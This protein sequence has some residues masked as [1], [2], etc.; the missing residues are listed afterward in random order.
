LA[1][2]ALVLLEQLTLPVIDDAS[3]EDAPHLAAG[4]C[5]GTV[6]DELGWHSSF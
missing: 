1:G 3:P 5:L 6:I 4:P 2:L